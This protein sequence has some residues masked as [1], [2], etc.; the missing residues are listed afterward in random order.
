MMNWQ[1]K[2]S[3]RNSECYEGT[4]E[5]GIPLDYDPLA[6]GHRPGVGR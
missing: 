2:D 6:R 3:T 4:P 1:T 5:E